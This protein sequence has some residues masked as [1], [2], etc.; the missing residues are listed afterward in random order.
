MRPYRAALDDFSDLPIRSIDDATPKNVIRH[1][2]A[3]RDGAKLEDMG[4]GP[5]EFSVTVLYT[6]ARYDEGRELRAYLTGN[7]EV[8]FVHPELGLLRGRIGGSRE[9]HDD[10]MRKC[11][12]AFEFIEEGV[13][14]SYIH[15]SVDIVASMENTYVDS[16]AEQ[17]ELFAESL[18][19]QLGAEAGDLLA[20]ELEED[21]SVLSQFGKLSVKARGAVKKISEGIDKIEDTLTTIKSP[22]TSVLSLVE[23]GKTLPD[24]VVGEA[25]EV[26]ERYVESVTELKS[27]PYRFAHELRR[28]IK[29]LI[30]NTTELAEELNFAGATR[31]AVEV[32]Y[33]YDEDERNREKRRQLESQSLFDEDGKLVEVD[34]LPEVAVPIEL[35]RAL[36]LTRE[37]LQ[38]C[39]DANRDLRTPQAAALKLLEDYQRKL[40]LDRVKTITLDQPMPMHLLCLQH[41]LPYATADRIWD[42]NPQ[43]QNPTFCHGK[44]KVYESR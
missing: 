31:L 8:S 28:N 12:I 18:K 11:E 4:N 32:A 6:R 44:V 15:A 20:A 10:A 34:P 23:F 7:R 27:F 24:R 22:A 38:E 14:E 1:E 39:V 35:E 3:Y 26:V 43:L 19:S 2:Y 13:D 17:K 30:S 29:E 5:R 9:R 42:L 25:A 33:I 37:W 21:G 40:E 36:M 16:V 41:N